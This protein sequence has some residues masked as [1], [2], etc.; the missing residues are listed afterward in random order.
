MLVWTALL[1]LFVCLFV[2]LFCYCFFFLSLTTPYLTLLFVC[3]F[4]V[5]QQNVNCITNE[6]IQRVSQTAAAAP[7]AAAA[8]IYGLIENS[9]DFPGEQQEVR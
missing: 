1:C 9:C 8:A 2:N 4:A 3:L 5:R 6:A 7:R